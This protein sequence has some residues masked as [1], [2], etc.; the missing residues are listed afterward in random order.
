MIVY[1]RYR[2]QYN[3]DS[4]L[5]PGADV[6]S[7]YLRVANRCRKLS[8][9]S[10]IEQYWLF[11]ILIFGILYVCLYMFVCC[12]C[13]YVCMY[14]YVCMFCVCICVPLQF[15]FCIVEFV[16]SDIHVI[17]CNCSLRPNLRQRFR[18]WRLV[19]RS[20]CEARHHVASSD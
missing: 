13:M 2:E 3:P 10:C 19:A 11:L 15:Y 18:G 8:Y 6:I 7:V 4:Q 20:T 9:S 1:H 12:L 16:Q 17:G 5:L 14:V